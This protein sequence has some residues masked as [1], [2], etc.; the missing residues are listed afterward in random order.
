MNRLVAILMSALWLTAPVQAAWAVEPPKAA[1]TLAAAARQAYDA[2]Q[3]AKAADL[4]LKAWQAE[5]SQ[6]GLLYNAARA[7]HVGGLRDEAEQRYRQFL[8]LP[9]HDAAV[10]AKVAGYLDDIRKSR[11]ED[12][13]KAAAQARSTGDA[14][15]AMALYRAAIGLAPERVDWL[16]P[17]AE[18][19]ETSG[20]RDAARQHLRAWLDA[21]PADAPQRQDVQRRVV[22]LGMPT[23]AVAQ[24]PA[25]NGSRGLAWVLTGVGVTAGLTAGWL[26]WRAHTEQGELDTDLAHK[27]AQG[28]ILLPFSEAQ[29]R[30]DLIQG[31][32]TAAAWTGGAAVVL[33]GLGVWWLLSGESSRVAVAPVPGGVALGARF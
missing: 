27:D 13:A 6:S 7:S 26:A 32:R 17:L 30:H 33:T 11:A 20:Q 2:G 14:H 10:D 25:E 18:V 29:R 23:G 8:E 16:L 4:Y 1:V 21:S 31:D 22:A 24:A 3:Y 5:P 12:R 15:T 19:E 28:R 9:G